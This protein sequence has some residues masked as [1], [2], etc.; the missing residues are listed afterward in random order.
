MINSSKK[1]RSA[2]EILQILKDA[3][4]DINQEKDSKCHSGSFATIFDFERISF[5]SP[6]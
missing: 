3:S 6:Y 2:E 5:D 4:I 1:I